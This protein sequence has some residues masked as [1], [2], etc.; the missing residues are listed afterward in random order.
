MPLLLTPLVLLGIN[1]LSSDKAVILFIPWLAFSFFYLLFFLFL[2][3]RIGSTTLLTLSSG[4]VS[5]LSAYAIMFAVF[6][7]AWR[8][9]S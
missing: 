6:S 1:N 7:Y 8:A 4:F 5:L 2:N 9:G 3:K